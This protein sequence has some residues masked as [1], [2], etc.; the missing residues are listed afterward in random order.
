MA[1]NVNTFR[2]ELE[3]GGARPSLFEVRLSPPAG[4][5]GGPGTDLITKSPFMVK[6]TNLPASTI[7]PLEVPYFG[8]NIKV[9]GNRTFEDWSVTVMNDEDFKIR[10]ALEVWHQAI[11]GFENNLRNFSTG[12]PSQYKAQ[13]T[14][15]QF[16]K[17]GSPIRTYTFVGLWPQT[18][19]AIDLA[20]DTDAIEEFG[21]T[22][23][24]DYWT[25]SG[26]TATGATPS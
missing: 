3:Q 23:S 24:Y 12:N 18:I 21:V 14:V 16:S 6:A 17:N 9:A 4:G 1:F 7:A 2:A 25:V 8:R 5:L 10:N 11:N 15:T 19:D 20:W 26:S 22:W 13:A